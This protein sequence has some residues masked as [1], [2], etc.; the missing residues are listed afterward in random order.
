MSFLAPGFVAFAAL[1]VVPIAIHLIGR[2]R[3][4]VRRFAA[5]DLLLRSERRVARR[6]KL[7]QL[8][9]LA[10]RALAIAAVPLILAKPFVEAASD[11]PGAV[12][13]S[14]SA[15]II[16]DDSMSMSLKLDGSTLLDRALERAR[17][18]VSA[19]GADADCAI[20]LGSR[21]GGAPVPELTADR[22]RLARALDAIRPSDR[23]TD[24]S[25]ALKRSAQILH[26]ASRP[27]RRV[28]LLSD[29]AAHGFER[30]P[31]WAAGA[32]PELVSVD[33]SGGAALTNRAITDL[34]V[35][36]AANL[37]PRASRI[38]VDVANFSSSAAKEVAVTLRVD[39]KAV[40]K[41]LVDVAPG[42]KVTKRFFHSFTRADD[43]AEIGMHDVEARLDPDALPDDDRRFVRLEVRRD[44]RVLVVDGD[45]RTVRRDDEVFYLE[46][47]LRPGDRDDSQL[48]VTTVTADELP[49]RRLADYD[50][51]FLC[52]VKAP[53]GTAL[54]EYVEGGGGLFISLGGN[55]DP[56][57]YD[58]SIGDLL[59][60]PLQAIRAV[61]AGSDR[62]DGE[63]QKLGDGEHLG[64][65]ERDHPAL[66]PLTAGA[67]AHAAEAFKEARFYRYAL[68]RPSAG[69]SAER[70]VLLRFESGSPALLEGR[71]GQ[72]RVLLLA[73]TI[74]RDWNDLPIQPIFLPLVQQATRYLAR[75]PM[76]DPEPPALVGQR[77]EIP[78]GDGDARV[79]VTPPSGKARAFERDRVAG[80]KSLGFTDTDEP[81]VYH[82]AVAGS[83]G[84][85]RPRPQ[86]S[87]VVNV[88]PAESD[89][90]RI[91]AARLARLSAG[92]GA[93][94]VQAPRRRV[95]LWHAMGAALLLLLL[96]EAVL[97]RRK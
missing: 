61:G 8:L 48:D 81:G 17:R 59:P 58:E 42:Q 33:V 68:F 80:R 50:V 51:V 70:R 71:V 28:Y 47:A 29:L 93:K 12:S 94:S 25:G 73:S 76:H 92:A 35:E 27:E 66:Q 34:R 16:I 4:K 24:L 90:T 1:F 36:P 10:V 55:V 91:D 97:L 6:T 54:R 41:G 69:A 15:V 83:D 72:G 88:D 23:A 5:I 39:G 30:D 62:D 75:A 19:L 56:D 32:G 87:F 60:Q 74:D 86:A 96:G 31:P 26:S 52:N 40:A 20:V 21:A 79:E 9:L 64:R 14:Q 49:R 11:L 77:H 46:T 63:I 89:V 78:L 65:V 3:A 44:L 45:P 43:A 67:G 82:V 37:G 95:E 57:A 84:T 22:A 53:D 85:L 2:S 13:G 38:S 18:I 7:R